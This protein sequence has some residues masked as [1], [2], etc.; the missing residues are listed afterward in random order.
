MKKIAAI[1]VTLI[2]LATLLPSMVAANTLQLL[3]EV[4]IGDPVS[5]AGHD[6]ISW[7][8][9]E[10]AAHPTPGSWGGFVTTGENARVIWGHEEATRCAFVTLDRCINPGAAQQIVL[11]HLDG[12]YFD[13]TWEDASFD[14][15]IKDLGGNWVQVFHYTDQALWSTWVITSI[16]LDTDIYGNPLNIDEYANV[17][18]MLCATGDMWLHHASDF[19]QVAFDW[20]QLW[21]DMPETGEGL[22]PGYWKN[23]LDDWVGYDP[24]QYFDDVFGVGPHVTL[25]QA[26][27]TGGGGAAALG[28]HATAALL[29]AAHPNINYEFSEA[30]IIAMVQDAYASGD[31][32][33][34]KDTFEG[35]NELEGDI[36]S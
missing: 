22:T 23:H 28:R 27:E 11:R 13:Y 19:G 2:L 14:V 21:G 8:P 30:E 26:L 33:D 18:V 34:V 10:P 1:L 15:F 32:E 9:V 24:A 5:E 35:Y 6:V 12:I 36:N 16:N 31:Y 7:G 29:N 4:N 20:I 3:C 17:E 25:L